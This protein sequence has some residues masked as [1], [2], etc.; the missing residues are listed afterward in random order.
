[1]TMPGFT[2][3]AS[4]DTNRAQ[5]NTTTARFLEDGAVLRP[6]LACGVYL[7]QLKHHYRDLVEAV[8]RRDWYVVDVM[9]NAVRSD[10]RIIEIGC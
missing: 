4:L 2:A 1:M 7:A 10:Q 8:A 3:E 5:Y 9:L 6:Q